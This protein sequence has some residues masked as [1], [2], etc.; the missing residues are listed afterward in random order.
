VHA[1]VGCTIVVYPHY[2]LCTINHQYC[3][4]D[5]DDDGDDDEEDGLDPSC[6]SE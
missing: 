5:D 3:D 4:D 1:D 6:N 2:D